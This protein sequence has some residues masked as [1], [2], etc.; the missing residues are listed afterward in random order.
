MRKHDNEWSID[1][2]DDELFRDEPIHMCEVKINGETYYLPEHF[3]GLAHALLLLVD[4]IND[5][6]MK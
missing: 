1:F 5:K 4:A 3:A 2:K 6:G